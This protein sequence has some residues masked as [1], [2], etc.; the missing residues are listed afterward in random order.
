MTTDRLFCE[1]EHEAIDE[2]CKANG[3]R[4]KTA[5]ELWPS[6]DLRQAHNRMDACLDPERR[7][8]FCPTEITWFIR[9]GR[10]V[11]CHSLM[12]YFAQEGAYAEPQTI[13]PETERDKID[14][15]LIQAAKQI[16]R[17]MDRADKLDS[18]PRVRAV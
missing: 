5:G 15:E 14:R 16:K 18:R 4:K 13:E 17:L 12:R 6:M 8:K 11:G 2:I 1:T 3:G 7:E 10:E 9:K